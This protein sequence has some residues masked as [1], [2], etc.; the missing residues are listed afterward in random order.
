MST[1]SSEKTKAI[2]GESK[3]VGRV[4]ELLA[5]IAELEKKLKA[6]MDERDK[7]VASEA[8]VVGQLDEKNALLARKDEQ[9][10]TLKS[11]LRQ[12]QVEMEKAL[13]KLKIRTEELEKEQAVRKKVEDDNER[14]EREHAPC[15]AMINELKALVTELEDKLKE[16]LLALKAAQEERNKAIGA[17]GSCNAQIAALKKQVAE[18]QRSLDDAQ[19]EHA[20]CSALIS[21]L[22]KQ[23]SA[24][25]DELDLLRKEHALCP[26]KIANLTQ[27]CNKLREDHSPCDALI[28]SLR[29]QIA[30]LEKKLQEAE[31][32]EDEEPVI[33]FQKSKNRAVRSAAPPPVEQVPTQFSSR[34]PTRSAPV[35]HI[36]GVG[37]TIKVSNSPDSTF[38]N[39]FVV[40]AIAKDGGAYDCGQIQVGDMIVG[41]A[42]TT[43]SPIRVPQS[44]DQVHDWLLGADG[45]EVI[46][47]IEKG[48][49]SHMPGAYITVSCLRK[50]VQNSDNEA[51]HDHADVANQGRFSPALTNAN[52]H[53]GDYNLLAGIYNGVCEHVCVVFFI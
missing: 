38:N 39:K 53:N 9:L 10:D 21:A 48:A 23:L 29:D 47:Q 40:M 51:L 14:L 35:P 34:V 24:G 3:Q 28:A 42:E 32:V 8:N 17:H 45:T 13:G 50:W 11:E 41:V 33:Q 44:L 49:K 19:K 18:L 36:V 6:A 16:A 27:E 12:A 43:N 26:E 31:K 30:N 22:Q 25:S 37:M 4:K 46:M 52:A 7:A 5:T 1:V 15:E 2:S 20:P